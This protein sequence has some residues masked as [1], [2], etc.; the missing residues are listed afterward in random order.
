MS[1]G[2]GLDSNSTLSDNITR[3]RMQGASLSA[4]EVLEKLVAVT[5]EGGF[6]RRELADARAIQANLASRSDQDADA[7]HGLVEE[8][9]EA[10]EAESLGA[11]LDSLKEVARDNRLPSLAWLE[12]P[13][14]GD[15][16]AQHDKVL[17]LQSKLSDGLTPK[18][19]DRVFHQKRVLARMC[20]L[21][22]RDHLP[23]YAAI[24]PFA[25]PGEYRAAIRFSNGQ[26]LTFSD[27]DPDVRGAAIKFFSKDGAETDILMTNAPAS[28]ARDA[29]QFLKVAQVLVEK[30]VTG[31]LGAGKTFL[32]GLF[33]ARFNP[34]EAARIATELN[35][36][37]RFEQTGQPGH[38]AVLGLGRPARRLCRSDDAGPRPGCSVRHEQRPE[39]RRLP[40]AGSGIADR[41]GR[42]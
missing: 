6:S 15:P 4:P 40:S 32:K 41:T 3:I 36:A 31:G 39:R 38:A 13:L 27:R 28:F 24:G 9:L 17:E 19:A 25:Q 22:V 11:R 29:D 8:I 18:G 37:D 5:R 20:R 30:Q 2:L 42:R 14:P 21:V 26:G 33:E 12:T 7:L 23:P 1:N 10:R 16:R 34:F 35:S